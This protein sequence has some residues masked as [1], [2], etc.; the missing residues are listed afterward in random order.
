MINI[1]IVINLN[2]IFIF[3]VLSNS[4]TRGIEFYRDYCKVESLKTSHQTELF[5]DRFNKLFDVLNIPST[6]F[7]NKIINLVLKLVYST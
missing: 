6:L 1:G 5:T 7:K 2:I 3:Q 4:M